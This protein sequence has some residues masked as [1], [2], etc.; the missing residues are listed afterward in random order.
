M[1][2]IDADKLIDCIQSSSGYFKDWLQ[3]NSF[4][5]FLQTLTDGFIDTINEQETVS[6]NPINES[7]NEMEEFIHKADS[8]SQGVIT[9]NFEYVSSTDTQAYIGTLKIGDT[10][11]K[12]YCAEIKGNLCE[13]K[14]IHSFR[15]IEL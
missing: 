13:N 8:E 15:F 12:V 3:T 2:L 9:P 4:K 14:M 6:Y 1:R 5:K 7:I 10:E 11:Y